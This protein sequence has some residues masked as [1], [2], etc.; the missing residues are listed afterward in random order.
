MIAVWMLYAVVVTLFL[1]GGALLAE[2][3]L[4]ALS[5]PTR[6]VW[7]LAMLAAAACPAVVWSTADDVAAG[8]APPGSLG[9]A[10]GLFDGAG[11]WLFSLDAPLLWAWAGVSALL[12]GVVTVAGLR[13]IAGRRRWGR[14][15]VDGVSVRVSENVGP[16]VVGVLRS[17]IVL[18]RWALE[19]DALMTRLILIHE[20]EHVTEGDHRLLT[21]SLLLTV[22][23]PWNPVIFW[24]SHRLRLAMEVDCDARV[25]EA[26][27]FDVRTYATLLLEVGRRRGARGLPLAAFS[28]PR[29]LLEHRIERMTTPSGQGRRA[30]G[31]ALAAGL[32]LLAAAWVPVPP[33]DGEAYLTHGWYSC[34][35]ATPGAVAASRA[36]STAEEA[37]E[38]L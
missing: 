38:P 32:V 20:R 30:A 23:M 37:S 9:F 36:T 1:A 28:R 34:P 11:P 21:L 18:P 22:L 27:S 19:C 29:S 7:A 31:L 8:G 33:S 25:L 6:R 2:K 14:V 12:A 15:T 24:M 4:H 3:A 35:S 16:A 10:A 13:V 17:E 26:S 5:R